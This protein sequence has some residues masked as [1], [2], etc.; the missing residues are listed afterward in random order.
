MVKANTQ[1]WSEP[2]QNSLMIR[3]GYKQTAGQEGGHQSTASLKG[4]KPSNT[5]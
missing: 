1:A 4:S 3:R 5:A 2:E